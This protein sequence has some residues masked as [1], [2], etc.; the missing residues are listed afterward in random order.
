MSFL[1]RFLQNLVKDHHLNPFCLIKKKLKLKPKQ[2]TDGC[3]SGGLSPDRRKNLDPSVSGLET[4]LLCSLKVF[5]GLII[6][7]E[8]IL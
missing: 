5:V 2:K 1:V 6:S 4:T 7:L 8:T 3:G